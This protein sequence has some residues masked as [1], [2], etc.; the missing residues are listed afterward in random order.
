MGFG[1]ALI[2]TGLANNL[3]II[4]PDKTIIFI[5]RKA[6]RQFIF[7]KPHEDHIIYMNNPDIS[8]IV[9][10][11]RWLFIKHRFNK[12]E[13]IQ[14]NM[15]NPAY[16]YWE[17]DT[18]EKITYKT[19]SHA[20]QVACNVHGI[21]NAILQPKIVLTHDEEESVAKLLKSFGL[22]ENKYICI[23]PHFKTSFSPNKAWF[24]DRWQN[25]VDDLKSYIAKNQLDIKIVQIG[26]RTDKI[27]N[28]VIDLTGKTSFR[29]ASRVLEQSI[30]FIGYEGG[31]V[32]LSQSVRKKSIVLISAMIPKELVAYPENV[33]FY[34]NIDCKHCGLKV[35]CPRNRECMQSITVNDVFESVKGIIKWQK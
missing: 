22:I 21:H 32:H 8:L 12:N 3:K 33:N 2:W 28:G 11:I 6:L 25:L 19:G 29:Q 17:K 13:I 34:S 23:E 5:Y 14:V 4:N 27:L 31:L 18:K 30:T 35:P 9:D 10:N 26:T 1:G 16:L 20:I 24:W 7:Q 15:N